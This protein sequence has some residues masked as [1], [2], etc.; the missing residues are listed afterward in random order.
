MS[1]G[2]FEVGGVFGIEPVLGVA[3][4]E[5]EVA[6]VLVEIGQREF[7]AGRQT[8]EQRGVGVLLRLKVVEGDAGE[9]GD[10]QPAGNLAVA[11]VSLRPRM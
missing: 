10:D 3:G 2:G 11:P 9:I 7:D 1:C 6:D 8:L 5:G 4:D